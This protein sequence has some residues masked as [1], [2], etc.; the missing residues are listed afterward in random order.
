M[1]THPLAFFPPRYSPLIP[2]HKGGC[3]KSDPVA[4]G[5]FQELTHPLSTQK[6]TREL[7]PQNV[8]SCSGRRGR[9]GPLGCAGGP[10]ACTY[11]TSPPRG[12]QGHLGDE[13]SNILNPVWYRAS[14]HLNRS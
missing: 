14:H 8:W 10:M 12:L 9:Q 2:E 5:P 4:F 3:P 6:E 11:G 7:G 1:F 13:M